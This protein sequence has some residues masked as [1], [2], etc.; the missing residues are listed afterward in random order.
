MLVVAVVA[1]AGVGLITLVYLAA[2]SLGI[3]LALYLFP[4]PKLICT[5]IPVPYIFDLELDPVPV[6]GLDG[7]QSSDHTRFPPLLR[8]SGGLVFQPGASIIPNSARV[9]VQGLGGRGGGGGKKG[10]GLVF[11]GCCLE[12]SLSSS[13]KTTA[14]A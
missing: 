9:Y 3:S 12:A 13:V 5:P 2:L 6:P 1:V 14:L 7:H 4:S 11:P 10:I 8:F